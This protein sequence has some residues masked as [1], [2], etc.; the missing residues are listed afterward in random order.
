MF[1][2]YISSQKNSFKI[3]GQLFCQF[4]EF[5]NKV[6]DDMKIEDYK[7]LMEVIVT[8]GPRVWAVCAFRF[9]D[10]D[11]NSMICSSDIFRIFKELDAQKTH[12]K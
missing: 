7:H 12:L 10:N 4:F 1:Q 6:F 9:W 5:N 2:E 11:Q 8:A 3:L